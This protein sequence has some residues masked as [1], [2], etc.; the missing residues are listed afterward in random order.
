MSQADLLAE[1][2][3]FMLQKL[4]R[5]GALHIAASPN[6]CYGNMIR[7]LL[8]RGANSN[9]IHHALSQSLG[10]F[11][12]LAPHKLDGLEPAADVRSRWSHRRRSASPF[13]KP[14]PSGVGP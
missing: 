12:R 6:C 3:V 8:P 13:L 1:K 2:Y 11:A 7:G 5:L 10:P 14:G 4:E 9:M